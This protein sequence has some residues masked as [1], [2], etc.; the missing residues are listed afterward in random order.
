M[1]SPNIQKI[2]TVFLILAALTSSLVFVLSNSLLDKAGVAPNTK[3]EKVTLDG[4]SVFVERIPDLSDY[5]SPI[6][7]RSD[8]N[9]PYSG[10]LTNYF[11][12]Q[13]ATGIIAA[14][15]D[16]PK[17]KTGGEASIN[18]PKDF[19]KFDLS[20]LVPAT[21]R[22]AVD[23]NRV[24]T[25]KNYTADDILTY[26]QNNQAALQNTL[27][28]SIKG[29][30]ERAA[31]ADSL[32]SILSLYD[33]TENQIYGAPVPAPL[34]GYNSALL[35]FVNVQRVFFD[36][37]DP[38][39]ALVALKNPELVL[40][41]YKKALEE[42]IQGVQKNLSAILAAAKT[43]GDRTALQS[44][45][46]K[47][48]GVRVARAL[49]PDI[50][51]GVSN[52]LK[53]ISGLIDSA[54][55]KIQA[56]LAQYQW[57]QKLLTEL[58]K[59]VLVA[60]LVA[61]VINWAQGGGTPQFVSNWK[62]F[63]GSAFSYASGAVIDKF[64]PGLCSYFKPL[65]Q[66]N[67]SPPTIAVD[68][69]N[70]S[71]TCTLDRV[72]GNLQD[73]ANS[74]RNG[75]WL[76]Y[77]SLLQPQ[78][79]FFGAYID[80]SDQQLFAGAAAAEAAKNEAVSA[81][82]YKSQKQC[83]SERLVDNQY[84]VDISQ[85]AGDPD[86]LG[87]DPSS[88]DADGIHCSRL[89]FCDSQGI[90]TPGSVIDSTVK[91]NV[92]S[93]PVN[94][95]V[96]AQDLTG[97]VQ[98]LV[99]A[100]LTKLISAGQKGLMSLTSSVLA[101]GGTLAD[102]CGGLTGT[103]LKDCQTQN[104]TITDTAGAGGTSKD[105]VLSKMKEIKDLKEQLLTAASDALNKAN[106][107]KVQLDIASTTCAAALDAAS[108]TVDGANT[109][110][111]IITN[112]GQIDQKISDYQDIINNLAGTGDPADSPDKKDGMLVLLDSYIKLLEQNKLR[113]LATTLNITF[114]STGDTKADEETFFNALS[115][116]MDN[117]GSTFGKLFG[118]PDTVSQQLGEAKSYAATI[119][120]E[121]GCGILEK[122]RGIYNLQIDGK[123]ACSI[124]V[125][126]T[127]CRSVNPP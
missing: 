32:A 76:A 82:G 108:S 110:G 49:L 43:E 10:N 121:G 11:A 120:I 1:N 25:E 42:Q 113:D 63:L 51:G 52:I 96:N 18:A 47:L 81:S 27:I 2:I 68:P 53:Y 88:C 125:V 118:T 98:A 21:Y 70:N 106:L 24:K 79:N 73:Y 20:A 122:A 44:A 92:G 17:L 56:F 59:N 104:K 22:V 54:Y 14:N 91:E 6:L 93:S 41:P 80:L 102:T 65:V 37:N 123:P 67:L 75:G 94:R 36:Q 100:G 99:N 9:L 60:K 29:L 48:L 95:I 109:L 89:R 101:A 74:F 111:F 55:I 16:G 13:L 87:P 46:N 57:I 78:N 77:G 45:I 15:P 127:V 33:Q 5:N 35:G 4:K 62:G 112:S 39:R 31:S 126:N 105:G 116:S 64:A 38:V 124:A 114:P 8:I 83:Q 86:F 69:T 119:S 23:R 61:Q 50:I 26:L 72:V 58:L 84:P 30:G 117:S 34:A 66:I 19:G 7:A 3:P 12:D 28:P 90:T 115:V 103:A 107:A 97:L 71:Y 85:F 40:S